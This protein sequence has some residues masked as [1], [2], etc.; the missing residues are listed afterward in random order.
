MRPHVA[1]LRERKTTL[2]TRV[3]L[4][5]RMEI[6]VCLEVVLFG[7]ALRAQITRVRL[8]PYNKLLYYRQI[9]VLRQSIGY[10]REDYCGFT[11]RNN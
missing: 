6:H 7:E 4:E 5:A 10:Y 11:S 3:W 9:Q 2:L 1:A 8:D